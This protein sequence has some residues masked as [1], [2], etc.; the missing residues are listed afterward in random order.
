MSD[1]SSQRDI[2]RSISINI[3][4]D[5][6]NPLTEEQITY[7]LDA[8]EN[9]LPGLISEASSPAADQIGIAAIRKA[10]NGLGGM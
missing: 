1:T 7:I 3:V 8:P 10:L 4:K 9:E 2:L 5:E 6:P